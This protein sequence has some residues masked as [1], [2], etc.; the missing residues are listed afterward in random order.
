MSLRGT[1]FSFMDLLRSVV[2]KATQYAANATSEISLG[3][4][5]I[6]TLKGLLA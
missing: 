5:Q 3:T 4:S 6:I 1:Y 2:K